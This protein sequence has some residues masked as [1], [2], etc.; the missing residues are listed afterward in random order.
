[1]AW[2]RDFDLLLEQKNEPTKAQ[3]EMITQRAGLEQERR[4]LLEQLGDLRSRLATVEG[5]YTTEAILSEMLRQGVAD[6]PAAQE[7][8][9]SWIKRDETRVKEIDARLRRLSAQGGD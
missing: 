7:N 6:M 2:D 3:S 4:N 9:R 5:T 1:M 8:L